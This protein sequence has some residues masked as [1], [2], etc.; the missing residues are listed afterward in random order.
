MNLD[1]LIACKAKIELEQELEPTGLHFPALMERMKLIYQE[2][3]QYMSDARNMDDE[4]LQ[5]LAATISRAFGFPANCKPNLLKELQN[6]RLFYQ[7]GNDDLELIPY[8]R[9]YDQCVLYRTPVRFVIHNK[10]INLRSV[11]S[12]N[13]AELLNSWG[14]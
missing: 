12:S 8:D 5:G 6:C 7:R 14:L 10:K 11:P 9:R 2:K 1:D 4:Q 3:R 13:V